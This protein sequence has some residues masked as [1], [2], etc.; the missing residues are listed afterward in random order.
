MEVMSLPRTE[1]VRAIRLRAETLAMRGEDP[2]GA[3]AHADVIEG[4]SGDTLG[5]TLYNT[6]LD[7]EARLRTKHRCLLGGVAVLSLLGAEFALNPSPAGTVHT[8]LRLGAMLGGAGLLVKGGITGGEVDRLEARQDMLTCWAREL[9]HQAP[10]ETLAPQAE[11]VGKLSKDS[12]RHT[13]QELIE[14]V[15]SARESLTARVDQEGGLR[16]AL[17]QVEQ[18][19]ERLRKATGEDTEAMRAAIAAKEKSIQKWATACLIGGGVATLA[20]MFG[21]GAVGIAGM[22]G[23]LAAGVIV[24]DRRGDQEA[25]RNTI[26]RWEL[27]LSDLKEIGRLGNS[28]G[29]AGFQAGERFV[30][31]GG[32]RVPVKVKRGY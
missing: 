24:Q 10:A 15:Q 28:P 32:V 3:R 27:Q 12:T 4:M 5:E 23:L 22:G 2:A 29:Q 14:L 19:L 31:V 26:E 20:A 30:Q 21:A 11:L 16:G 7:R 25:L 8:L 1:V 9:R 17:T 6:Q 13:R 18:D